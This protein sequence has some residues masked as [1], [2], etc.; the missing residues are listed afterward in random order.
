MIVPLIARE[1]V[2]GVITLATAESGKHY[3]EDDLA[4]AEDL[5]WRAGTAVDNARLYQEV[6]DT[7]RLSEEFLSI[8][9]HELKTPL[10]A[11]QLQAQLL[12]RFVER[13]QL[14]ISNEMGERVIQAVE[15]QVKRL[16]R[17]TNDLLDVSR[18]ASGRFEL[19]REDVDLLHLVR[20][21]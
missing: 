2:F 15:R 3:N 12:R 10:T 9:S 8:A 17:L 13:N 7:L 11:L 16:S 1:R 5:A 21:V 18:I 19:N 14:G 20:E 6:Q 4:L